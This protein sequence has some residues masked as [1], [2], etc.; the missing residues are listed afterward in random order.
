MLY[1]S[2][3]VWVLTLSSSLPV[4]DPALEGTLE[5]SP[6]GPLY[7]LLSLLCASELQL[8][9]RECVYVGEP[10]NDSSSRNLWVRDL[11]GGSSEVADS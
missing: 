9:R 6:N 7:I 2:A 10:G 11:P 3:T 4:L 1:F 8:V 5:S